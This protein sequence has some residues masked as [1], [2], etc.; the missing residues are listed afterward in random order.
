MSTCALWPKTRGLT[1]C[2]L[3][4][5]LLTTLGAAWFARDLQ[6]IVIFGF[7]AG[8]WS[9]AAGALLI[10]LMIVVVYALAMD[11]F[12]RQAASEFAPRCPSS[13]SERAG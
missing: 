11:R 8:Y 10:Y 2:L 1:A 12:E 7:P 3:A 6:A 13:A 4:M 5:W 9:V